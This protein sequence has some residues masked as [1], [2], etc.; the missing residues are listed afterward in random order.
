MGKSEMILECA[1]R[2]LESGVFGAVF[3]ICCRS[4]A[5]LV[6]SLI[7]FDDVVGISFIKSNLFPQRGQG[8]ILL[9]TYSLHTTK[10]KNIR[11]NSPKLLEFSPLTPQE[12]LLMCEDSFDSIDRNDSETGFVGSDKLF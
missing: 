8:T 10:I 4:E 2:S 11:K 3:W 6:S 7:V 1:Y 5:S 9:L 12:G